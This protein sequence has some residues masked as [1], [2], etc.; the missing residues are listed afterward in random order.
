M[1]QW[2]LNFLKTCKFNNNIH[3]LESMQSNFYI[4]YFLCV[5]WGLF[6]CDRQNEIGVEFIVRLWTHPFYAAYFS[7]QQK[8]YCGEKEHLWI[9]IIGKTKKQNKKT[10]SW[11]GNEKEENGLE[12]M[13]CQSAWVDFEQLTRS[14]K[15]P[16][17]SDWES[18]DNTTHREPFSWTLHL[19]DGTGHLAT[20]FFPS[21]AMNW[22]T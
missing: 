20:T 1:E 7:R 15:I 2:I 16:R 3:H 17:L 12:M 19:Y 10:G 8:T 9:I 4:P 21:I 14:N 5:L 22:G 13:R 18:N 6:N 11:V